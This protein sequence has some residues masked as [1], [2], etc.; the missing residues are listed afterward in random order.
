[1]PPGI[2]ATPF[3]SQGMNEMTVQVPT[4][5]KAGEYVFTLSGICGHKVSGGGS[6]PAAPPPKDDPWSVSAKLV[7][8][9]KECDFSWSETEAR[10]VKPDVKA[11]PPPPPPYIINFPLRN[12]KNPKVPPRMSEVIDLMNKLFDAIMAKNNPDVERNG[13]EQ[14]FY[15]VTEKFSNAPKRPKVENGVAIC[16][17]C[18]QPTNKVT[19][20]AE[21]PINFSLSYYILVPS[22]P[23]GDAAYAQLKKQGLL[24]DPRYTALVQW[25]NFVRALKA[26]EEG[27]HKITTDYINTSILPFL[28]ETNKKIVVYGHDPIAAKDTAIKAY[29]SVIA[30]VG[31][32]EKHLI[33]GL[34]AAQDDYDTN[35]AHGGTQKNVD[36]NGENVT[37]PDGGLELWR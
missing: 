25:H 26:H 24:E 9:D 23:Q 29:D 31:V 20:Y 11:V 6:G 28:Q 13:N 15:S 7:I 21:P 36:P 18:G 2:T 10:D 14:G 4:T 30:E 33:D 5:T 17:K 3:L 34:G 35:S 22:W 1:M 37:L 12:P 8:T 27:H 16:K 19:V 32:Q